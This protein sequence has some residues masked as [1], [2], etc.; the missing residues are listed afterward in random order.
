MYGIAQI[1]KDLRILIIILIVLFLFKG[2]TESLNEAKEEYDKVKAQEFVAK[3]ENPYAFWQ[4]VNGESCDEARRISN[5]YTEEEWRV[6]KESLI[7]SGRVTDQDYLYN[8]IVDELKEKG[9]MSDDEEY[10]K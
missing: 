4:G 8:E 2:C 6:E 7:R 3:C 1:K 10:S 9:I 5:E